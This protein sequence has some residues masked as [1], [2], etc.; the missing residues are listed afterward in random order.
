MK[1]I[2]LMTAFFVLGASHSFSQTDVRTTKGTEISE[3]HVFLKIVQGVEI[4]YSKTMVNG[5]EVFNLHF[6]NRTTSNVKFSW[7]LTHA[8]AE[9]FISP[10]LITLGVDAIHTS[11]GIFKVPADFSMNNY[12]LVLT[13]N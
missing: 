1:K 2:I 7:E 9:K 8:H 4:A 6:R 3:D 10:A 12:E 5:S 13:F 11:N